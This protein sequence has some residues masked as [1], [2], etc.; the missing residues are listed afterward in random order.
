MQFRT[1]L[2]EKFTFSSYSDMPKNGRT[3]ARKDPNPYNNPASLHSRKMQGEVG[4]N[5]AITLAD[6]LGIAKIEAGEKAA[7]H[8]PSYEG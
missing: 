2:A 5:P 4:L 7:G 1:F 6:K 8:N 3:F